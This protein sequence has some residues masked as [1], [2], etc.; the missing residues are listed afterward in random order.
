MVQACM[1]ALI[2]TQV[3]SAGQ[4][5]FRSYINGLGERWFH[6]RLYACLEEVRP[7]PMLFT[8]STNANSCVGFDDLYPHV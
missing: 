8:K 5:K 1:H 4:A 6:P 3:S 2:K 7:Q